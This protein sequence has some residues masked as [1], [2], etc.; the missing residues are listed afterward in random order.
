M[1][2]EDY[3]NPIELF[4]LWYRQ[5]KEDKQIEDHTAVYLATADKQA[6]PSLRAVLLKNYDEQGFV[7]YTNYESQKGRELLENPYAALTFHWPSLKKQI[8]IQGPVEP[9]TQEEADR[10]FASRAWK[11]RIGAWASQQ[12]RPM[13]N[14]AELK[15][16]VA[17]YIAKYNVR[18]IPRPAYWS[19][20]RVLPEKI[21]FWLDGAYRLHDRILYSKDQQ[22]HWQKTFLFP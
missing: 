3:A 12:S 18:E 14:R 7:F 19:G 2:I 8:R 10:Y 1:P 21:E 17:Y 22:G 11:S 9:V 13:K 15:K 4:S 16:R 20:F 5:A 6:R